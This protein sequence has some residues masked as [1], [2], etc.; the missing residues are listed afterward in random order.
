MEL[1][2]LMY[3]HA[4]AYEACDH[5]CTPLHM[6]KTLET[7][8]KA[9]L[10]SLKKLQGVQQIAHLKQQRFLSFTFYKTLRIL[11]EN[12]ALICYF[13]GSVVKIVLYLHFLYTKGDRL[14]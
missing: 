6:P 2:Q 13:I 9:C 10:V 7:C 5:T 14:R 4:S 12:H 8:K 1:G 3:I 11:Q